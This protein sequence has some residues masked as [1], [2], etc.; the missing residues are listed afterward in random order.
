LQPHD[1]LIRKLQE[2]SRFSKLDISILRM[3][4]IKERELAP[5]EDFIRQGDKPKDS[6]IVLEGMLGRYHTLGEGRR[7]YLS[8]HIVGDMPDA[9]GLFIDTM[10]HSV[11]AMGRARVGMV[12]HIALLKLF[13]T[14]P[15]AGFAIWRETLIDAAIFRE[16]ITNNS[17]RSVETR[18]AHFFCEQ[19]YRAQRSGLLNDN[20]C[21]L[22]LTQTQLAETM[23]V[24]LPSI[25][26]TLIKL[27]KTKAVEF[28]NGKLEVF[29]WDRLTRIGDFNPSYLHLKKQS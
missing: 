23:A 14:K 20:V 29:N 27:R 7:Q 6:A 28:K 5:G 18:V 16:A 8:F 19:Y 10:D 4:P 13:E 26:R 21:K 1:I 24:S 3:L 11:C 12:P 17:A 9:Q 22:P 25:S 15:N 2:H